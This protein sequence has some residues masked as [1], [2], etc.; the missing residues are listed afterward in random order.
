MMD[1]REGKVSKSYDESIRYGTGNKK[2]NYICPRFW[3]I[4]DDNGKGRSLS[5]KQ[6]NDGECGGW[7]AVIPEKASKVPKG[8]RIVEFTDERFHR[9]KS[10]IPQGDP[11]R[12]LVYRPMYPGFQDPEKHPQNLCVPCFLPS[13]Q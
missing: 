12:K 13:L 9:D 6:V 4:R 10:G 2:Y 7:N 11:A 8:K 3:C 1:N 5:F